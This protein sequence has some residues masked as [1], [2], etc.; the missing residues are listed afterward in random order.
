[1]ELPDKRIGWLRKN[2]LTKTAKPTDKSNSHIDT[3]L[4]KSHS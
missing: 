3:A 2:Y 4:P 1:M